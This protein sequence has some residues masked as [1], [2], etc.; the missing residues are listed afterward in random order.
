MIIEHRPVSKE[1]AALYAR[2]NIKSSVARGEFSNAKANQIIK[3][4][5]GQQAGPVEAA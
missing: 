1:L 3:Q 4:Q 2:M 5:P